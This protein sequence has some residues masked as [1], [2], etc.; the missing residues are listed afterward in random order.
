M[1]RHSVSRLKRIGQQT[2]VGI[3]RLHLLKNFVW[4]TGPLHQFSMLIL[5]KT[6]EEMS[7]F[8][9]VYVNTRIFRFVTDDLRQ[10][11]MVLVRMSQDDAANIGEIDAITA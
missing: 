4:Y 5:P 3:K 8:P 1:K 2:N 11:A 7:G 10:A 9:V 6:P